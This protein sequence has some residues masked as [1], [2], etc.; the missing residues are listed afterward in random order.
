MRKNLLLIL[1]LIFS[2]FSIIPFPQ[3]IILIN[4]NTTM[5]IIIRKIQKAGLEEIFFEENTSL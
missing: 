4:K 2:I 1:I 3:N 5:V